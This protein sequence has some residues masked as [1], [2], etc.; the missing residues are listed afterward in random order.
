MTQSLFNPADLFKTSFLSSNPSGQ[1]QQPTLTQRSTMK[2]ADFTIKKRDGSTEKLDPE[3]IHKVCFYACDGI[4]GVSVSEIEMKLA[5]HLYDGITTDEITEQVIAAAKDLIVAPTYNYDRVG[6][7]M[8]SYAVRKM[9]YGQF[10][11]WH[12]KDIITRNIQVGR[13]DPDIPSMYSDAE[14]NEINDMIVHERDENF[15]L[16]G[17]EQFRKKYLVKD[18]VSGQI[19]ESFQI[20]YIMVSAIVFRNYSKDVRLSYVKRMYDALSLFDISLPTPIMAG[21]RTRTKQFSSC[22]VVDA[23]DSLAS[24][25]ATDEAA[26]R[27]VSV[28]AGLGINVGRNRG[29]G[30]SIRQGDAFH[31]GLIPFIKKWTATIKSCSQGGVR[32]GAVTMYYPIWHYEFPELVVL[33]DNALLEE[34]TNRASDYCVQIN[35][36]MIQRLITG[37]NITLFSPNDVPGLYEAFFSD[38]AK[39][40]KLYEE[41]ERDTSIRHKTLPAADVFNMLATQRMNTGRIYC[42]FVDNANEKTPFKD[43]IYMS[44]LCVHGLTE[45]TTRKGLYSIMSLESKQVEVWNGKEWSEVVPVK[46]GVDHELVVVTTNTGSRLICTRYHKFYLWNGDDPALEVRAGWLKAGDTLISFEPPV[47]DRSGFPDLEDAFRKGADREVFPQNMS[48]R[49]TIHFLEGLISSCR[50]SCFCEKEGVSGFEIEGSYLILDYLKKTFGTLGVESWMSLDE[51]TDYSSHSL[52]LT[53]GP[54]GI[55]QLEQLGL[56]LLAEPF[57]QSLDLS[58]KAPDVK[59]VS[60]GRFGLGDTYCFTEPKRHMAVFNGILTGNCTEIALPTKPLNHIDDEDGEISLCTLGAVNFGKI[61]KAEDLE[62]SADL[63]VRA[64][65]EILD[66]QDYPVKAAERSTKGRRPLGVGVIGLAHFLAKRGLKYDSEALP[67]VD[68]YAEAWSYY[69]IKASVD[70]AKEKGPC[71]KYT[72]TK[73]ALGW[74]PNMTRPSHLDSILPHV[75]RMD[76]AGL[77]SE[78]K[79]FGI[80]NSTLMALMPSETSSQLSN[81]TNGIEPPRSPITIKGSKDTSTPQVV[82]DVEDLLT[83][84]DWLWSQKVPTG[85][86]Q[87]A[88]VFQKYVDQGISLDTS[89]NPKNFPDG[90]IG[91][92]Q[93]LKDMIEAY[94]LGHKTMYYCNTRKPGESDALDIPAVIDE[95]GCDSGACKI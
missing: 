71:P 72:E 43:P 48:L 2:T 63:L 87:I 51:K 6:G 27:Y 94:K 7:R 13:Y 39:F 22:V 53:I 21:L 83:S 49:S 10:T 16:A 23:G 44:N 89:Y 56:V 33:K 12:L 19:F 1:T 32:D 26:L 28:K 58:I 85:Y 50:T 55:L 64:L 9:A 61:K 5:P 76:W 73:Y 80:R 88:A 40:A 84:Y 20:P 59:V 90:R 54:K 42:M 57:R 93:L 77:R 68:R 69:L 34:R 92:T 74:T 82:P 8:V 52:I 35:K 95:S 24:I 79:E 67:I 66:Y 3:K 4:E 46:T 14:W 60:L 37:G 75:E 91:T 47:I 65:D 45:V 38:Q 11:P 41:Y 62:S 15:R 29:L 30:A 78:L 17:A 70:L 25:G 31:T 81:E 36:F 18:R 86:L